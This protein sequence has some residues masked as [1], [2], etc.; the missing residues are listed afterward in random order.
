[1][2]KFKIKSRSFQVF[3]SI[4][5]LCI[6][7]I[8]VIQTDLNDTSSF[9]GIVGSRAI[10]VAKSYPAKVEKLHVIPGQ[11]VKKGALL[12]ELQNPELELEMSK[13][14]SEIKIMQEERDLFLPLLDKKTIESTAL[15]NLKEHLGILRK[16]KEDLYIFADFEG[17]IQNINYKEGEN[18]QPHF[19]IISILKDQ[20]TTIRGYIHEKIMDEIDVEQF[21]EVSSL[22]GNIEKGT[23]GKIISFGSSIVSFPPRLLRDP[24]RPIWGREVIVSIPVNHTFLLGEKVFIKKVHRTSPLFNNA[25]ALEEANEILTT[26]SINTLKNVFLYKRLEKDLILKTKSSF[27]ASGITFLKDIKKFM[28]IGDGMNLEDHPQVVLLDEE[29]EI[30]YE[31]YI[32]ELGQV[33]DLEAITS[34]ENGEVYLLSSLDKK[35]NFKFRKKLIKLKRDGLQFT[36][37]AEINL[38]KAIHRSLRKTPKSELAQLV[39]KKKGMEV[40]LEAILI[41]D[42][43]LYI[44]LRNPVLESGSLRKAIIFKISNLNKLLKTGDIPPGNITIFQKLVLKN[45]HGGVLGISGMSLCGD[46]LYLTAAPTRKKRRSGAIFR[47]NFNRRKSNALKIYNFPHQKPEGVYCDQGKTLTVTFDHGRDPSQVAFYDIV[48]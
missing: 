22:S 26:S 25:V 12:L 32:P 27:E 23:I 3:L 42:N 43:S 20:P 18:T 36:K 31:N 4:W 41:K 9:V 34:T 33:D 11:I 15:E 40:D 47:L 7:I 30:I 44:G 46:D 16:Q 38:Y 17:K 8:A 19:P 29:G 5:A 48:K 6:L 10:E 21:V 45:T 1:M 35:K 39:L 28:A 13:I 14:E 37:E 2:D 24:E